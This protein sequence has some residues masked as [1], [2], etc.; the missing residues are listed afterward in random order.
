MINIDCFCGPCSWFEAGS[1]NDMCIRL[2]PDL[3]RL[4]YNLLAI[5]LS[6]GLIALVE[7]G[8]SDIDFF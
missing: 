1:L 4:A 8:G 7:L 5:D 3:L 6:L 2:L